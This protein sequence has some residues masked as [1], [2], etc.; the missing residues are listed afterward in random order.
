[1]TVTATVARIAGVL[2][3]ESLLAIGE[4]AIWAVT[5]SGGTFFLFTPIVIGIGKPTRQ[6]SS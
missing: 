2:E 3:G 5:V 6:P 1:V 4:M